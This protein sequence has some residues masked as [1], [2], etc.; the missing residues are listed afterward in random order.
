MDAS[1]GRRT[2]AIN[3][4]NCGIDYVPN[5]ADQNMCW[6]EAQN[7]K[8]CPKVIDIYKFYDVILVDY[9]SYEIDV[10]IENVFVDNET[11]VLEVTQSTHSYDDKY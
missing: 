2:T 11:S 6:M 10:W 3:E 9:I 7:A 1:P 8:V 5:D 4:P